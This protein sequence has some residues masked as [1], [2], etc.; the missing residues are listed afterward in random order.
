MSG[1]AAPGGDERDPAPA[2]HPDDEPDLLRDQFRQ[3]LRYRWLIALGIAL[4][5]LGGGW[6]GVSGADSYTATTE[7]TVRPL[8]LD[9]SGAASAAGGHQHGLRAAHRAQQRRRRTRRG[10]PGL[11][12]P[13][14]AAG[15]RSPGHQ[16]A[17]HPDAALLLHRAQPAAAARAAPMPS[18]PPTSAT[19]SRTPRRARRAW[20]TPT[21]S[22]AIRC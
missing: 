14:P 1:H 11:R 5:V 9:S 6:L 12:A 7:I 21:R 8:P 15:R 17:R 22:S 16:P 19:A 13:S 20:S 10:R 3:L 4:G 18:P 2:V